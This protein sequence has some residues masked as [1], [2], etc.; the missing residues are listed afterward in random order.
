ML[1]QCPRCREFKTQ[2]NNGDIVC[3]CNRHNYTK[4]ELNPN[5]FQ[6]PDKEWEEE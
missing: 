1:P 6:I 3:K 2:L 5:I 4:E